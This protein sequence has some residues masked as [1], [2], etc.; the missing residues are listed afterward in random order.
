LIP[1]RYTGGCYD[2]QSPV[3]VILRGGWSRST[4]H[5]SK[6]RLGWDMTSLVQVRKRPSE[7]LVDSGLSLGTGR[8]LGRA[9]IVADVVLSEYLACEADAND[10]KNWAAIAGRAY[11]DD[12]TL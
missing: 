5:A 4:W 3:R 1:G 7:L 2:A 6:S 12:P 8:F 11:I 10:P 9:K